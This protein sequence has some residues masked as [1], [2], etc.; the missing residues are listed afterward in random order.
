METNLPGTLVLTPNT[1]LRGWC[2]FSVDTVGL[3][4]PPHRE[5]TE[6]ADH[7]VFVKLA[8]KQFGLFDL[9]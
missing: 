6:E 3:R 4:T 7:I 5:E 2:G 1:S 8:F 9:F